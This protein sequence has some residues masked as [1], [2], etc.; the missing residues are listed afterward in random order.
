LNVFGRPDEVG[1]G[2]KGREYQAKSWFEFGVLSAKGPT[3]EKKAQR[4]RKVVD[5]TE[6]GKK[7]EEKR[8]LGVKASAGESNGLPY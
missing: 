4:S 6:R 3:I 7:G 5:V 2:G 8:G 1:K